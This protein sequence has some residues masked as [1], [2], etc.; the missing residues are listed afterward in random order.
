[1]TY[2]RLG[3]TSSD[4]PSRYR[5]ESE[6]EVWKKRDPVD[7]FR[8]YLENRGSWDAERATALQEDI[9]QR[10]NA[11]IKAAEAATH[12]PAESLITDVFASVPDNLQRHYDDSIKGSG[13][14][15]SDGHFPL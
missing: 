10:V 13:I 15:D 5:D 6:V 8:R 12:P 11:A 4:D 2:R 7:R 3:H 1:V 9:A 14:V